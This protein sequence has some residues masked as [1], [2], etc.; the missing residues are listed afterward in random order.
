MLNFRRRARGHYVTLTKTAVHRI[1][2]HIF[3][4]CSSTKHPYPPTPSTD[5]IFPMAPIPSGF[6][7]IGPQNGPPIWKFHFFRTPPE[8]IIIPCG[9]QII[10]YF[11]RKI[12]NFDPYFF[13]PKHLVDTVINTLP[14]GTSLPQRCLSQNLRYENYRFHAVNSAS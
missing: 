12:P 6:S 14:Q 10:S 2:G 7:K 5:G 8:I 1:S 11:L 3:P 13:F 4:L 9:N